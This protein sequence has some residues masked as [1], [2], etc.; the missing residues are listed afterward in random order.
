MTLWQRIVEFHYSA[1]ATTLLL[2]YG[3]AAVVA[4]LLVLLV[5]VLRARRL[6]LRAF[7]TVRGLADDMKALNREL[8]DLERR[9]ERRLDT[10]TGEFDARMTRKIDQKGDLIQER[11]EQNRADFSESVSRLEARVTGFQEDIEAFRA[12]LVDV[13]GR[14]PSLFDQLDDFR[15]TLAHSFQAE[16]GTVLNSFDSSM[17][18]ILSEMK[19]ELRLG[20]SRIESIEGMVRSRERAERTLLGA[21]EEPPPAEEAEAQDEEE[22]SE[23]AEWEEEARDLAGAD[24]P[25]EGA[26][27]SALAEEL[28][29]A[30]AAPEETPA[31]H[32]GELGESGQEADDLEAELYDEIAE[33]E[34]D[35]ERPQE[36]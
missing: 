5:L 29:L 27:G 25:E 35:E 31:D 26:E 30:E 23:F 19:S 24:E 33:A 1:G 9:V 2:I 8:D 3:G 13:E 28:A 34:P 16:L 14:I 21:P 12:R 10:R 36:P 20:I 7:Q 32:P 22:Q 6:A 17:G 11:L 18:A 15:D 4:L